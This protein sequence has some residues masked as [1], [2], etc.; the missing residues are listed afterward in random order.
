MF[1]LLDCTS[2]LLD[3]TP[4]TASKLITAAACLHNIAKQWCGDEEIP[5][6][7][8]WEPRYPPLNDPVDQ[9]VADAAANNQ[10][11]NRR[12]DYAVRYFSRVA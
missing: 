8:D 4:T 7:V 12:D 2:G 1:R 3:H 6:D 11:L 9:A 10:E 5:D